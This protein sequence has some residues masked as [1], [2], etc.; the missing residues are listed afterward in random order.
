MTVPATPIEHPSSTPHSSE[1]ESLTWSHNWDATSLGPV[2]QWPQ[3][4]RTI[5][6]VLLTSRFSMWMGWGPDLLFFYNDAYRRDTLGVKHPW[7]LGRPFREVWPEIWEDLEPRIRSVL[8]GG[9][10]TW[11][12]AL[13]LFLERSGYPEETYHTF[14]YSPLKDDS[15]AIT[16]LLS[17]VTEVT[18]RVIGERR[19]ALLGDLGTRL[20]GTNTEREVFEA[21]RVSL[22][23]NTKDLPFTA[24]YLFEDGGTTARR[25]AT[26]GVEDHDVAPPLIRLDD[27]PWPIA[28]VSQSR[29]RHL[30]VDQ[31]PS[32]FARVPTGAWD[33]PPERAAIV[34]FL[35]RGQERPAGFVIA[36]LNPYRPF[37]AAYQNFLELIAGQI[38]SSHANARAYDEERRRAESLAEL[39]RAKTTFFSNVSHEFR[40]PLTL[41]LS[42]L[43]DLLRSPGLSADEREHA[44]IAHR[45]GLRLLKLVN[46]LLDF[47]RME[48]G[49]VRA[50]YEPTDLAA[51]TIELASGFDSVVQRAGLTLSVDA[52][53]LPQPVYVDRDM[54]E[55]VVLNLLSNA[56]K[57]TFSGGIAVSI[58]EN[59]NAVEVSVAD[60]GIGIAPDELPRV[61]ERFHRVPNARS[62]TH[63]GTG[64]GLAL[65]QEIVRR[66][67]G[68][69][70]V[71][72][73]LGEGTRFTVTIPF[74]SGHLPADQV[75]TPQDATGAAIRDRGARPRIGAAYVEEAL[76]W[77]PSDDDEPRP[78]RIETPSTP[79][80]AAGAHARIV[81][82]DDN[83]DMRHYVARLLGAQGWDVEMV[84]D[85]AAA[86]EAVRA[87]RPDLV[88]SD[89]MMPRLDGFGL[90][91]ALRADP[92]TSTVPVIL[93]SARAGEE[94][95]V[96]GAVAA[97][98]DYVVKP[99]SAVELVARV[100]AQL[101]L[102]R[103]RARAEAAV[104]A[105]RDL[106]TTVLEQAPVGIC[107]MRG[108]EYVY[109]LANAYYRRFLPSD[110]RIIGQ[111]VRDVVPE[112]EGQGFVALLDRVRSTGEPYI[113]RAVEIVY[114]R[115]GDGKPE[116]AFLNLLYYPFYERGGTI[117]G[118]IAVVS[119]VTDEVRAR[120]EAEAARGEAEVARKLADEAR[121]AAEAA[122]RAKSDFLAVMSHELRTP[123]NAI[124]GY[125]EL[126]EMGIHGPVSAA[127]RSALERVARSQRHL[128]GLI[129]DVLNLARIE[130][131]RVE[132]AIGPVELRPLVHEL[133]GMIEPQLA[134][135]RLR[136]DARIQGDS[137]VLLGDREKV[138]QILLNLLSNAIKFTP[139]GGRIE[140]AAVAD[141]AAHQV[142]ITVSDTGIGIPKDKLEAIFEPFVQVRADRARTRDGAGLGL[143]ISRDLARGM[144][145]DLQVESVENRGSTFSLTLPAVHL[146]PSKS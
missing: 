145:G 29:A 105:A 123:L 63:E 83:A 25:L 70:A 47:S 51:F 20:S 77:L 67:G 18:E 7:A 103:E 131:G 117:D 86:L 46:S 104:R 93:L 94:A 48:A 19:L 2:A 27:A 80:A 24:T 41:M 138:V 31:L 130:T 84:P 62:R 5:V 42:P 101:T 129:N 59:G 126:I 116:S 61:F 64:I 107:V 133:V 60:T 132:Y 1:L 143:S 142:R 79:L 36:G 17:V 127:Q 52:R 82:A 89:V 98:D 92:S 57:H 135:K 26:T 90:L 106:L 88:L 16:G 11:D 30:V 34:P 38:A 91:R 87:R 97:A 40:T 73:V 125:V 15:G 95:R 76:R 8:T 111:P 110:R 3:S 99:F 12:E 68:T 124:G 69:I 35:Q 78:G 4:L 28:E 43:E 56:F 118:V 100:G 121:Q 66:H 108:P 112:A 9:G 113:G 75:V 140:L 54:W 49:R 128:L 33:R 96:E 71:D 119:E 32:R 74:G 85:G 109:E 39:D 114:D 144:H 137:I 53:P 134:E 122:N 102:A 58:R 44:V 139:E 23:T 21:V 13:L 141:D 22:A 65:V 6:D 45:N 115:H 136:Y 14:S 81:L 72:S 10:A 120:Q 55:K 50:A 146:T 37:D